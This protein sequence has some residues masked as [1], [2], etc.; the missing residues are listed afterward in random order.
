MG[1]G[2]L[3]RTNR[4]ARAFTRNWAFS[5]AR[6]LALTG[7]VLF[8]AL[9]PGHLVSQA[10]AFAGHELIGHGLVGKDVPGPVVAM[11]CHDQTAMPG[12]APDP[13]NPETP[14]EECPFCKGYATFMSAL[15]GAP[16]AGILDADRAHAE[17]L[18]AGTDTIEQI[19]TL[20]NNRGPPRFL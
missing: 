6:A 13:D 12:A 18:A 8:T 11:P 4:L 2:D 16:D 1:L 7:M 5:L 20:T 15:A 17:P 14:Q 9:V 3:H 19:A 10:A